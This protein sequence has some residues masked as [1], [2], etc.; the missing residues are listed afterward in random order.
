MLFFIIK[1]ISVKIQLLSESTINKIATGEIIDRPLSVVKELVEN[2]ID[3]GANRILINLERGGRTLISVSDNG[4]GINKDSL[5]LAITRYATSKLPDEDIS[6]IQYMGFRGEA[7]AAMAVAGKLII[8]TKT[9]DSNDAWMIEG[10][11]FIK[12][13]SHKCGTTVELRDIFCSIPNRI[14][15]LKAESAEVVAC[16]GLIEAFALAHSNIKFQLIHN[17]KDIFNSTDNIITEVFGEDFSENT[18]EFDTGDYYKDI[19]RVR[20]YGHLSIPTYNRKSNNKILT[21]VNKRLIKDNFIN[22]LIR[23]AYFNTLP[24]RITPSLALFIDI[25]TKCIDINIHPNKSEVRF[26]DERIIRDIIINSI[27]DTI[28]HVQTRNINYIKRRSLNNRLETPYT[29]LSLELRDIDNIT[30]Y[31]ATQ[32]NTSK[33]IFQIADKY[34]VAHKGDSL[35]IVDQHAAHERIVL[36]QINKIQFKVQNFLIPVEHD[37]GKAENDMI[38]SMCEKLLKI[39]ITVELKEK[40]LINS[41]P[42]IPGNLDVVALLEDIV[43]NELMWEEVFNSHADEILKK[44]ACYS[45]IR[46]GRKLSLAE[47]DNLLL[48]IETTDFGSQCIHGRPTYLELNTRTLDKLFERS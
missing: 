37:F 48:L 43:N 41:A 39:G 26:S 6:N 2:A 14:R 25:P 11:G 38:M 10:N 47:M 34:I 46:T 44:V 30:T 19:S 9:N 32:S 33:A 3:S 23:Q 27:R 40:I 35:V 8:S 16:K 5:E 13:T 24:E 17:G 36:E 42:L 20:L 21:F 7:L 45:S 31:R 29:N 4:V 15:F 1:S 18:I 28:R 12:P 22:K